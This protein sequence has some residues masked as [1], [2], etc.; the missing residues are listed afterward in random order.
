VGKCKANEMCGIDHESEILL[1][2]PY[3]T[4]FLAPNAFYNNS[5]EYFEEDQNDN[6]EFTFDNDMENL[7]LSQFI[8]GDFNTYLIQNYSSY[9]LDTPSYYFISFYNVPFFERW[10]NCL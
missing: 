9:G 7:D 6:H 10:F 8:Y 3:D 2:H 1:D 5:D 4:N